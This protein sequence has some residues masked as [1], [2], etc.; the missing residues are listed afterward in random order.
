MNGFLYVALGGAIGASGRYGLGL[1]VDQNTSGNVPFATLS[2]NILGS[3]LMGLL[4]AWLAVKS[5]GTEGLRLLL[6][7]GLLGGFTT[8]SSFSLDAVTLLRDKGLSPFLL[9]VG[10]SVALSILA[11]AA[12]VWL[13]RRFI[14]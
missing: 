4:V 6:G 8:F 5:G 1:W 2:V 9:Y 11:I 14:S 7:V 13:M 12:G 3:F 10:T